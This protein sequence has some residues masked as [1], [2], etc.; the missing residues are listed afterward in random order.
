MYDLQAPNRR[1]EKNLP[2]SYSGLERKRG[3][4]GVEKE[5]EIHLSSHL[6]LWNLFHYYMF[7]FHI[8][9]YKKLSS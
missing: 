8:S 4:E 5:K 9:I 1:E 2:S 3:E 7:L 6:S